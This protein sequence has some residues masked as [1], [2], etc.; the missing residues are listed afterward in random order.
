[1][2]CAAEW[3][4]LSIVA[5]KESLYRAGISREAPEGLEELEAMARVAMNVIRRYMP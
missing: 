2:G 3:A 1:M 5:M 4:G